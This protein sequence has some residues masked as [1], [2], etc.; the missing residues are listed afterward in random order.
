MTDLTHCH[1]QHTPPAL[2]AHRG[3]AGRYP[4]NTLVSIRAALETGVGAVEFDVQFSRDQVPVVLH[5]ENLRRTTGVD[6][7]VFDLDVDRIRAIEI[8][9]GIT[10]PTLAEMVAELR[11]WPEATAF[12]EIKRAS[13]RRFG[14]GPVVAR[15][16]DELRPVMSNAVVISFDIE[17]VEVARRS[18]GA[19]IGWV[20]DAW[21]D[22]VLSTAGTLAPEYLFCDLP[23]AGD[24]LWP[25]PWQW[26]VYGVETVES[27]MAMAGRGAD[28][29][30]TMALGVLLAAL[31][32]RA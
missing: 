29:V 14:V 28:L 22:A 11:A 4:E 3:D 1:H 32:P 18:G 21:D 6:A 17:A 23:L 19:R 26:V 8:D 16:L 10:V 12:V 25:G 20:L 27:A 24:P 31:E 15:V 5:D 13:L 7:A 9:A 2:V 30:E